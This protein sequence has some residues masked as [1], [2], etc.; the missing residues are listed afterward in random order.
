VRR[1]RSSRRRPPTRG[2]PGRPATD[3]ADPSPNRSSSPCCLAPS[4]QSRRATPLCCLGRCFG[5]VGHRPAGIGRCGQCWTARRSRRWRPRPACLGSP[6][7]AGWSGIADALAGL[8]D[9]SER[10]RSCPHQ[11]SP[12]LEARECPL[13]R[14]R[15]RCDGLRIVHELIRGRR[16]GTDCRRARRCVGSSRASVCSSADAA[17]GGLRAIHRARS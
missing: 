13:R 1:P 16:C 6:C 11:A 10:W 5:V 2:G 3:S 8:V 14:A 17:G 4:H 7:T 15:P 9:R 12:E